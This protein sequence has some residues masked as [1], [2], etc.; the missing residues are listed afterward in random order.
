M[1]TCRNCSVAKDLNL[2]VKSKA[3]K[4]GY[5]TICLDCSRA[6]VKV[7]RKE[8]P[9]KR[10]IQLK[11]ESGKNYT[12]NKHLKSAYGITNKDYLELLDKQDGNCAICKRNQLEFK[13][14]LFV[15]HCHTTGK[16][17]GL[18]CSY[19]NSVLGYAKDN[20]AVLKEAINYLNK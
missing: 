19:C 12:Y 1:K 14:R 2:F 13:K 8:N 4:S 6:R 11:R 10:K 5:D 17:R 20:S 18:L 15:D 16:I 9:E 7:W 3:F